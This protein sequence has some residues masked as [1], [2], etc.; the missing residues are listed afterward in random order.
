MRFDIVHC[1]D[2][3]SFDIAPGIRAV[4]FPDG[5]DGVT[6]LQVTF[7][8]GAEWPGV[9][10]H[11]RTEIVLVQEGELLDGTTAYP[12]GTYIY[13]HPGSEHRPASD[14]GCTVLA[15]YPDGLPAPV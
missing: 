11:P 8:P 2:V 3:P 15:I 12:A 10:R 5:P 6:V 1:D 13:G 9:D 14:K 7:S 4:R